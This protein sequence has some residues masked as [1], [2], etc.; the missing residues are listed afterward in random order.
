MKV[1]KKLG[2]QVRLQAAMITL[3]V[4]LVGFQVFLVMGQ[5]PL[6]R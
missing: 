3:V 2:L 6:S 5:P 4:L 1:L